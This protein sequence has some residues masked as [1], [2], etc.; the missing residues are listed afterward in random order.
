MAAVNHPKSRATDFGGNWNSDNWVKQITD[1]GL[2]APAWVDSSGDAIDT[3]FDPD[4]TAGETTTF[5]GLPGSHDSVAALTDSTVWSLHESDRVLTGSYK[6]AA[7]LIWPGSDS[8]GIP[9]KVFMLNERISGTASYDI[10]VCDIDSEL[11]VCEVTGLGN[12]SPTRTDMG[13]LSNV[14]TGPA[15]WEVQVKKNGGGGGNVK[16]GSM[17]VRK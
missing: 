9:Q 6:T 8:M 13:T 2:P 1:A 5:D 7:S 4:L 14:S 12:D 17:E 10:R 3:W 15:T 16:F 11:T